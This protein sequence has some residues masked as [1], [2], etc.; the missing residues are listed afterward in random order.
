MYYTI[1]VMPL[2]CLLATRAL[3]RILRIW[4]SEVHLVSRL[5]RSAAVQMMDI[6]SRVGLDVTFNPL[7]VSLPTIVGL[8]L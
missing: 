4:S 1:L 5:C 6:A 8:Q 3:L 7:V 2:R